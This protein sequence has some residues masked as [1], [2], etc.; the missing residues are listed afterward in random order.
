MNTCSVQNRD[1]KE[2]K[3]FHRTSSGEV[4]SSLYDVLNNTSDFYETGFMNES[5]E[6][7]SVVT[8]PMFDSSTQDGQIQNY[9]KNGYLTGRQVSPN[10]FEATDTLSAD[11]L[12]KDL[13]L[14]A[15]NTFQ[16]SGNNFTFAKNEAVLKSGLPESV[17]TQLKAINLYHEMQTKK[18]ER[19]VNYTKDQLQSMIESFMKK[20][21]FSIESIDSYKE[22]YK[23]KFGIE[24]NAEALIDF[25]EKVIAVK[26]GEITLDQLSEE[27]SHFVIE[28]WN[29]DEIK[30]ML[31]TVNNT[32]EYIQHAEAY[33]E[34]YSKQ[35]S[36]PALLEEAVRREVLGK[37]L[38]VSLQN[39][40]TL[41][42]RTE[43][44]ANFFNKL[45]QIISDFI[46]FVRSRLNPS[47]E[48]DIKKMSE[49]IKNRLYNESLEQSLNLKNT[50]ILK[51]MYSTSKETAENIKDAVKGM[52][53]GSY[54][55][56][57]ERQVDE[58]FN[59]SLSTA[60]D[61]NAALDELGNN[62]VMSPEL[63][64]DIE[65]LLGMEDILSQLASFFKRLDIRKTGLN[66]QLEID[67]AIRFK[68]HI[69][70]KAERTLKEI[71]DLKGNFQNVRE[72]HDPA[73]V[74]NKLLD[75][76]TDASDTQKSQLINDVKSGIKA[77][78]KDTSG[79]YKLFGHTSKSSNTFVNL[80]S[81]I[82]NSLQAKYRMNFMDDVDQFIEPLKQYRD[83]LKDFV[84]DG[85]FRSGV[86]NVKKYKAEREYELK[87]LK[88][89]YG[90]KYTDMDIDAYMTDFQEKGLPSTKDNQYYKFK[91][92]Y[93]TGLQNE[94]WVNSKIKDRNKK[95]V[96]KLN[97]MNLGA[98]PW[99]NEFYKI[100][101]DLSTSRSKNS[102]TSIEKRRSD[103]S[104][105]YEGGDIKQGFEL[106]FYE[107]AKKLI[108]NTANGDLLK[109]FFVSTN[110]R[111]TLFD[112]A[113]EPDARSLVFFY[114]QNTS[115]SQGE[116]AFNYMKWNAM[117]LGSIDPNIKDD[118]KENFRA[119]YISQR[120]SFE[121]Q[122]LQGVELENA[123]K[124]WL[125]DSLFFEVTEDYWTNFDPAGIDF[126]GFEKYAK[127][128]KDKRSMIELE[129]A[130]KEFA[131]KKQLIVRKYKSQNDYKEVDVKS[132]TINDKNSIYD[133]E[134]QMT[135]KRDEIAK[136]FERNDI[137]E[138]YKPSKGMS[139]ELKLNL[140]FNELFEETIGIPFEGATIKQI[141]SFFS[142]REHM[143]VDK[144]AGYSRL[145][146]D[147]GKNIKSGIVEN[148]IER[149][150]ELGLDS[151]NNENLL[152][153]YFISNSPSWYKRY[154]A[155]SQYDNFIRDYS[156]GKLNTVQLIEDY[157][158]SNSDQVIYNGA[159]LDLMRITPSFKYSVPTETSTEELY[160]RYKLLT[161]DIE[162]YNLSREMGGVEGVD[163][164][165][166]TDMTDITGNAENLKAYVMMM[167]AHFARL[168][169]DNMLKKQYVHLMAQERKTSY[170]RFEAFAKNKNKWDQVKDYANE[171][172]TFRADDFEDS[173]QSLKV[174][175]YGYY[176]LK[177]EELTDDVFHT[178][179]WGLNN[180][181]L[182]EQR[183]KHWR[184]ATSAL[185]GLEGQEFKGK[186]ATDTNYHEVMKEMIDFNFYGKTM[187]T[188]IEFEVPILG[189]TVDMS[190]FLFGLR[191]FGVSMALAFS[192][193]VAMTNFSGGVVQNL[194]MSATGRNI[195]SPSNKRALASLSKM[196][197]ESIKDIGK[198][199]PE[200]KINKIMYSF[201]IYNLSERY[202]NAKYNTALRLLPEASFALMS[203]TNFPLEAQSVLTKLMEYRLVDGKFTSWRAFSQAE[204][205]KDS[206]QS[207]K[208]IKSKFDAFAGKSMYDFL[209]ETGNFNQDALEKDGYE[210]DITKDKVLVMGAIRSIT[211]QTTMEIAK[212][213][214]GYAGRDPRWSFILSLKKWLVMATST[215]FSRRRFD[216]EV[217]GEEEGLIHTPK[218]F[219]DI[220]KSAIKDKQNVLESYDQLDEVAQK[221]V[222][223]SIVIAG[224][225]TAM[226][227]IAILLKNAAD[228][229]DEEEN[230]LLQLSAYMALRNLNE[231]FSGNVGIGQSYFEAV[232]NPVMLGQTVK[233]M[234]NIVNFGDIGEEVK[235]GKYKG[236]D[237]YLTGIMKA[238]WL[239]NP[240]TISS[241][242]AIAETR[243]SYEFFNTK[244]SFY[245]IFDFIPAKP[246]DEEDDE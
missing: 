235:T 238:T 152:K 14:N 33:R 119:D 144:F 98:S 5:D 179:V 218:Y 30:R 148:Y 40:F 165:Y 81:Q 196:M 157:L 195:Y 156:S 108:A 53:T 77:V 116:L 228:D 145:K 182:Y 104:P 138:V 211:E 70:T 49:D 17:K 237:K 121:R 59:T 201:G 105:Y 68:E 123:V 16:R 163:S 139:S 159:P 162:K 91:Y 69:T 132:M 217:G 51:V 199:D 115:S 26:N 45:S 208:D 103:S 167:D 137:T 189:R 48:N 27:F 64:R 202:S 170:E 150:R 41:E 154:D 15:Y 20:V 7:T 13:L 102:K 240:Y 226:L 42:G 192:P 43:N 24:P 224:M 55:T 56:D 44:E 1:T 125:N 183:Q 92:T 22:N 243:K 54:N 11:I 194:I 63:A 141:E 193:V 60:I 214:E 101:S 8:T 166:H 111:N 113:S 74:A 18:T 19:P 97:N 29:Q 245:H 169:K 75:D 155:N 99:E 136:L 71:N 158:G 76:Y 142:N 95:F 110:P 221:N 185:H 120:A 223:T 65:T 236:E 109:K 181:N 233:N 94:K 79:W 246:K 100:Q 84:K 178:L 31:Q 220:F 231:A 34:I 107:D 47:L 175:K 177:P 88:D 176:R 187:S 32:Q 160:E 204:K 23:N 61:S 28:M 164:E 2:P 3:L 212:H 216:F 129:K 6:F 234:T 172:T 86:D 114:N 73:V 191:N 209:D 118:L 225:L 82:I 222:K 85:Y 128:P 67:N 153:A 230:Y 215:V 66:T 188:K 72:N 90:G 52:E 186:K 133:L 180:A 244:E 190:K 200:A 213:H 168:A 25:Q 184:D 210:G 9:I 96:E 50:P 126:E 149:A 143:R 134:D 124:N 35:I 198:F 140:A 146:S 83:K 39:D 206:S 229:D 241:T 4:F 87:I 21:G 10:T 203:M 93:D 242:H 36:D 171:I 151:S 80:L 130:Y 122:G 37:M 38:A 135:A 207:D 232:Q 117:N 227:G 205:V 131:L 46:N 58:L 62:E 57:S 174:P 161:T 112:G 12:E 239:R 173:F 78:Q 106:M 147:L 127:Y 197:P 89:V 219:F